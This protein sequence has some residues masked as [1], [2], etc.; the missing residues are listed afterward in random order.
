[1]LILEHFPKVDQK[2]FERFEMWC[3]RRMK[4][5]W[6]DRVQNAEVLQNVKEKRNVLFTIKRRTA[7]RNDHIMLRNCLLMHVIA[8]KLEGTGR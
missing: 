2:Q 8:E 4:I 3:W 1:L 6:T 5:S 7:N